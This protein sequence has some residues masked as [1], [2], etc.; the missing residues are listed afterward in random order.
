MSTGR[1]A[2]STAEPG[3][4]L[5][6]SAAMSRPSVYRVD[7]PS[8][9]TST[10][11]SRTVQRL[12]LT[13]TSTMS[14]TTAEMAKVTPA[15][16]RAPAR[17]TA[18]EAGGDADRDTR[19]RRDRQEQSLGQRPHSDEQDRDRRDTRHDR[20]A[21]THRAFLAGTSLTAAAQDQTVLAVDEPHEPRPRRVGEAR[22]SMS[23]TTQSERRRRS[24]CRTSR[25]RPGTRSKRSRE[26]PVPRLLDRSKLDSCGCVGGDRAGARDVARRPRA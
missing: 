13:T 22:G 17:V 23:E 21:P 14:T 26:S 18:Y 6:F 5:A 2:A 20:T 8:I 15:N 19:R 3:V 11:T 4:G 7:A 24:R 16:L 1:A 9:A 25:I 12:S 10:T